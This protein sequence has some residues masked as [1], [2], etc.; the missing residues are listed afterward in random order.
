M[1]QITF[2]KDI[3]SYSDTGIFIKADGS[4][5][6]TGN[7]D[8]G[9]GRKIQ[10]EAIWARSSAGLKL[11]DDGGNGLLVQDGGY[12]AVGRSDAVHPID[13][14]VPSNYGIRV[15]STASLGAGSGGSMA[16]YANNIPTAADQ[17]LGRFVFGMH[18]QPSGKFAES[19]I[20]A[21]FSEEAWVYASSRGTYLRFETVAPGSTTRTEKMRLSGNGN[22]G[23]G[24]TA[25]T[26]KL[27]INS[28]VLR[29]RTAKT[30]SGPGDTG[31]A[32]DICWDSNSIYICV[33]TN[34]WKRAALST[35]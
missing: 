30:P 31:N 13:V 35:W 4:R 22:L 27:D 18:D 29:L 15:M 17:R 10:T 32:G 9:A 3:G 8:V 16:L 34:T 25:P 14:L 7:W 24:T 6:L 19:A 20:V 26:A 21:A 28:N 12:I 5:A 1:A 23:V 2:P 33:A 11:F